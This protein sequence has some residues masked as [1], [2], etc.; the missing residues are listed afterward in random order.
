MQRHEIVNDEI[1]LSMVDELASQ[2]KPFP[3]LENIDK[4]ERQGLAY[5]AGYIARKRSLKIA[6]QQCC[7]RLHTGKMMNDDD[8]LNCDDTFSYLSSLS[9]GGLLV[10]TVEF[11]E[12]VAKCNHVFICV[13]GSTAF[14]KG[15]DQRDILQAVVVKY[16]GKDLNMYCSSHSQNE[17]PNESVVKIFCN[18]SLNRFSKERTLAVAS[19]KS[20]KLSIFAS[21][22]E[23]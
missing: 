4:H 20:R 17:K 16:L 1:D 3:G 12:V 8:S 6:C 21:A 15:T 18:L 22:R 7:D 11:L 14:L 13:S 23:S 19:R 9:R 10:P 2:L 5:V